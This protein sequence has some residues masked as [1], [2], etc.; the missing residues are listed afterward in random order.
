VTPAEKSSFGD[1]Q[2]FHR[3][4][5]ESHFD[6]SDSTKDHILNGESQEFHYEGNDLPE[7]E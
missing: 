5:E 3:E 4:G 1:W 2:D 6:Y 7:K